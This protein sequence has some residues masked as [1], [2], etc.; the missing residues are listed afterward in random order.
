M[1]MIIAGPVGLLSCSRWDDQPSLSPVG[2][3]VVFLSYQTDTRIPWWTIG[4]HQLIPPL[5]SWDT[6]FSCSFLF[7]FALQL[8]LLASWSGV[9]KPLVSREHRHTSSGRVFTW[10]SATGNL[11]N[12]FWEG[13]QIY[14]PP[15]QWFLTGSETKVRRVNEEW[16][17]CDKSFD[18]FLKKSVNVI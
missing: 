16:L 10:E 4:S 11:F 3:G 14:Y 18:I 15:K 8:L 12:C 13:F 2:G 1:A 6:P 9:H 17:L 5:Y 7:N